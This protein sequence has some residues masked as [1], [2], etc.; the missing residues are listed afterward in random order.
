MKN[1][2]EATTFILHFSFLIL[3]S[4]LYGIPSPWPK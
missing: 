4:V 2:S 3:N 1:E